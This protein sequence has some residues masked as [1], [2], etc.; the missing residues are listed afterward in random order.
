MKA[1]RG[2]VLVSLLTVGC[3]CGNERAKPAMP[4]QDVVN[5]ITPVSNDFRSIGTTLT[6]LAALPPAERAARIRRDFPRLE[7]DVV[8]FL[9]S[10]G[11]LARGTTV[12]NVSF[13]FG[14]LDHA[15][16]LDHAGT[17]H[18]GFFKDQLIAR[19]QVEGQPQPIDVIVQCLNG[20]FFMPGDAERLQALGSHAPQERF[21]IAEGEGLIQHVDYP[22]AIRRVD[23]LLPQ[24][25]GVQPLV[26]GVPEDRLHLW[27]DEQ[28]LL[29]IDGLGVGDRRHLLDQGAE[30]GLDPP[31]CL[32]RPMLQLLKSRGGL[33]M[34]R[35]GRPLVSEQ[36]D[37][38]VEQWSAELW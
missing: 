30:L 14:S 7:T 28:R 19:V 6:A 22:V 27:A 3:S 5:G 9:R 11:S 12:T 2:L 26:R 4:P 23:D 18:S 36:S 21:V 24:V 35:L 34:G 32:F 16:A 29:G 37:Q 17:E 20:T 33:S 8:Y 1:I 15:R 25:W 13:L 10:R 38:S 31:Q